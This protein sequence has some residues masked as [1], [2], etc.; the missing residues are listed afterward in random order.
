M[1]N[2]NKKIKKIFVE[3]VAGMTEYIEIKSSAI[4]S[5]KDKV[6]KFMKR[7]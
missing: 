7:I 6:A 4:G 1:R 5:I 2:L 3:Y